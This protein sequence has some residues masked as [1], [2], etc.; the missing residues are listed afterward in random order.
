[1]E[2]L[3]TGFQ[4]GVNIFAVKLSISWITVKVLYACRKQ[5][6][7]CICPRNLSPLLPIAGGFCLL[8]RWGRMVPDHSTR[9]CITCYFEQQSVLWGCVSQWSLISDIKMLR[10]LRSGWIPL[11]GHWLHF[12]H[13]C[14][15][16]SAEVL[17]ALCGF[18][19]WLKSQDCN[20]ERMVWVETDLIQCLLSAF[21]PLAGCL[22]CFQGSS[23]IIC[24]GILPQRAEYHHLKEESH[25][26]PERAL[27]QG[28]E[29]FSHTD[30]EGPPL[31]S[32]VYQG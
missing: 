15:A 28:S 32:A 7:I 4:K 27:W 29:T 2:H 1:M 25:R 23:H 13:L 8:R 16:A 10:S 22:L 20:V 17:L 26:N 19:W 14:V 30:V 9:I 11:P 24:F 31:L 6:S 18:S 12:Q 5:L 21:A 3:L